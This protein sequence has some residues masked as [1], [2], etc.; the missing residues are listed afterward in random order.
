[1]N[2]D[3]FR[4]STECG[5]RPETSYD[6][7]VKPAWT[8]RESMRT[9]TLKVLTVF[10]A[11]V[12]SAQPLAVYSCDME[13]NPQQPGHGDHSTMQMTPAAD[14]GTDADCCDPKNSNTRDECAR[15]MDCG[16]CLAST[17]IVSPLTQA[18]SVA[19]QATSLDFGSRKLLP[20]HPPN[21]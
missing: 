14:A 8:E 3:G 12:V 9:R 17:S 19:M 2:S 18:A 4:L 7:C 16:T 15:T 20:S 1:L 5:R 10:L 11:L 13:P 6:E 21:S